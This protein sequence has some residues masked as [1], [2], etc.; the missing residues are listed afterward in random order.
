[1]TIKHQ[2]TAVNPADYSEYGEYVSACHD[3]RQ[4]V[5]GFSDWLDF[6]EDCDGAD[7]WEVDG[8]DCTTGEF[9]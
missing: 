2:V 4:L 9:I 3:I 6:V 7:C 8:F 5:M 1:V